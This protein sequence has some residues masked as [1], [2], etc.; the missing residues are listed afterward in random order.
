M[1]SLA[2][3]FDHTFR[4]NIC[5]FRSSFGG[6]QGV[7]FRRNTV[8]GDLIMPALILRRNPATISS[9]TQTVHGSIA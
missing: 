9:A 2:V 1:K 5:G 8:N 7:E 6:E 3:I 4:R